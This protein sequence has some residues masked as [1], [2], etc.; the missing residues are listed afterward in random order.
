MYMTKRDLQ[1]VVARASGR[2]FADIGRS[3][4]LTRARV[5]QIC[6]ENNA[7]ATVF[8]FR[9]KSRF[10]HTKWHSERRGMPFSLTLQEFDEL[11][12]RPCIYGGGTFRTGVRV[13]L[14]RKDNKHGYVYSN[15]A[16][17]CFRHNRLRSDNFTHE[18]FLEAVARFSGLQR[19]GN[20]MKRK[21]QA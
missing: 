10:G 6:R 20:L 16:P 2:T 1:I 13:G 9:A 18:E 15:C 19:C 12:S 3:F 14:D 5:Q 4:V 11:T 7:P 8:N 17:C 21:N